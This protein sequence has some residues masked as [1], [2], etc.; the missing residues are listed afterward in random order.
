MAQIK[1]I[2]PAGDLGTYPESSELTIQLEAQNPLAATV[3][4]GFDPR[5]SLVGNGITGDVNVFMP[6]SKDRWSLTTRNLP[7]QVKTGRFPNTLNP[8]SITAQFFNPT[9]P[10]RGGLNRANTTPQPPTGPIGVSSVGIVL[11]G[12]S[13]DR[14]IP[15]MTDRSVWTLNAPAAALFGEDIYGGHP[16]D[17]GIY[18][19]RDST[20][21]TNDAWRDVPGWNGVYTHPDGHSKIIGWAADGYPIYGPMGYREPMSANSGVTNMRSGFTASRT[22]P[23]RPIDTSTTVVGTAIRRDRIRI[24][25]V[26][27]VFLGMC[28]DLIDRSDWTPG[29]VRVIEILPGGEIR[30]NG[31]VSVL[32]K[33]RIR[34]YY[35]LGVFLEDWTYTATVGT[36]LDDH[37]GRFCVTPDFPAGT[38]AYFATQDNTGKPTYPYLIG[39]TFYGSPAPDGYMGEANLDPI[40]QA[41]LTFTILS[42]S[43][44]PGL[45]LQR[46][47]LIYGY[48]T[49]TQAGESIAKRYEFTVR[50]RN[51]AGQVTDRGFYINVNDIR[52]P[53]IASSIESLGFYFD[54]DYVNIQLVGIALARENPL[55]W[56]VAKGTLPPGLEVSQTGL[57]SGFAL[58]PAVAGPAGSAAYDVGRY[59]QFVWDF[60]GSTLSRTYKFTVRIFDSIN[61]AERDYSM[62]VYAR[63]FF[64]TDNTLIT[65]DTTQFTA[66]VDG[67]QYPSILTRATQLP[68]VRQLQSYAFQFN[69]YYANPNTQVLWRINAS[70]P[71][72][73]DQ[74]AVPTPDDNGNY[75]DPVS[76]DQ[77]SF[78]QT[79]LTLPSGLSVDETTGWLSGTL[80]TTTSYEQYYDFDVVAYVRIAVSNTAFSIR[81]SQPVRFRLR[82]LQDVADLITWN[83]PV[84]LGSIDNGDVSTILIS[85]E[86][87]TGQALTYRIKSGQYLRIPQGLSLLSTGEISGRTSFDYFSLDRN[88]SQIFFDNSTQTY[89]SKFTFT[90][91]AQNSDATVY[92]E[93]AFELVVKNVN[94]KPY[95]NLYFKALLPAGLR[96]IFRSLVN[97]PRLLTSEVLY[98]PSDPYFGA[99]NDL[100]LLAVAGLNA[101]TAANYIDSIKNY[102]Y[103]KQV[104]LG[105]IK[106]AV[107]RAGGTGEIIYEVLYVDVIDYNLSSVGG[108]IID[109]NTSRTLQSDD[110][111]SIS[112][113]VIDRE[114]YQSTIDKSTTRDDYGLI[115]DD[116]ITAT[117]MV[118]S[119]SFAN[120][121][122]ELENGIGFQYKGAL[123]LWMLSVQPDT[124]AAPGF[125]R[126]LVLAYANPG[127][128]DK[129]LYRYR[130][131]LQSSGFGVSDIMN[132]FRFV[133]DRYLW[134]RSLTNNYDPTTQSFNVSKETSFDR[135]PSVGVV[136]QGGWLI[137]NVNTNSNI[138]SVAYYPGKGYLAVGDDSVIFNSSGGQNWY[139]Q[140][141]QTDLSYSAAPIFETAVN[142]TS[143]TFFYT[144]VFTVGDEAL[145]QNG[146]NANGH[147][148]IT[149]IDHKIRLDSNIS[150]NLTAGTTLDFINPFDGSITL[151]NVTVNA[152][153]DDIELYIDNLVDIDR[154]FMVMVSGLNVA[155]AVAVD[156]VTDSTVVLTTPTTNLIPAG[157]SITFDNLS[158]YTQILVTANATAA[159]SNTITFNT[160]GNVTTGYYPTLTA[161]PLGVSIRAKFTE[162]ELDQSV[163]PDPAYAGVAI[164]FRGVITSDAVVGEQIISLSNTT[165]IGV[166]SEVFNVVVTADAINSE[167]DQV[168]NDT[169]VIV[170]VS[171]SNIV[172]SIYR[173]MRVVSPLLPDSAK[174]SD[175]AVSLE[176]TFVH[177]VFSNSSFAAASN[178][179]LGFLSDAVTSE[180][181]T[182]VAKTATSITLSDPLI[183]DLPIGADN[184]IQF[185]LADTSLN[186]VIHADDRWVI[187]GAKGLVLDKADGDTGWNQR[188]ALN[189][190]DLFAVAYG[191]GVYIAVGS[192]GIIIRSED[193]ETWSNPV[194]LLGNRSLRS[195]AYHNGVWITVGDGGAILTSTNNGLT[196]AIDTTTTNFRL[197][198]V[199]YI[200]KWVA[201]GERGMVLSKNN[202]NDIW[203]TYN[204]GVTDT[205]NSV[206]YINN[207]YYVSGNRGLIAISSDTNSWTVQ[208]RVVTT[209]L[210]DLPIG[211]PAPVIVGQQGIV[212][213]ESDVFTVDWAIRGIAFDQI[214]WNSADDLA[215]NGYRVKNGELLIFAQQEGLG[216]L[217]D[218]WNLYDAPYAAEELD[219]GTFDS[220][221]IVP[222]F[223]ENQQNTLIS[224]QRAGIWRINV[225]ENNIVTLNFI[226][227]VNLNQV[228]TVKNEVAKLFLDPSIKPGNTVPAYS[229]LSDSTRE[230][231]QDTSFDGEGTRFADNKDSYTEPGSLDKYLKFLKSGV[232]R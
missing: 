123:P 211:A 78:D 77:K 14:R 109:T 164:D 222:G 53:V 24:K 217:N 107:A 27:T 106:K 42:G 173:G 19:Y 115:T 185:G 8:N 187:V 12:P 111:G 25:E 155:S 194:A 87:V 75:F 95:E 120:M 114:D 204:V 230:A 47:G 226:R 63:S 128:G 23:D 22:T 80:G 103:D 212:L 206:S 126:A 192:E 196:W 149:N 134:D 182:V 160:I 35:P 100:R 69:A 190:G 59:D 229:L 180:G 9:Y 221:Q 168:V 205:L 57:I 101:E 58:A 65:V 157:T 198:K 45:Q 203:G 98:R 181:T 156:S 191:N 175:L 16:A 82:V 70:G 215:V 189:Y 162:I 145:R 67:Y 122:K 113:L 76:Y 184:L 92:D 94:T 228:V 159:N 74:G 177:L 136:D 188:Y 108:E 41:E 1:W 219:S 60:E 148:F 40:E 90:V 21:I 50:I 52:P 34:A 161:L 200:N 36:A 97:D 112:E 48:P 153:T 105:T 15:G 102:H 138:N 49:V 210:Y 7:G 68:S 132:T 201:V 207:S 142:G 172:G 72:V 55:Q 88:N 29:S 86:T 2:T 125:T 224:N 37:N 171:N 139:S 83:T 118:Y 91:I 30:L 169:T 147:A 141:Q 130:S 20:F 129:L 213:S 220:L 170:T 183:A 119:N 10:Y 208:S 167:W 127:Q 214:N 225:D 135:I 64:R 193:L 39:P 227:Q 84:D 18:N 51:A 150:A 144:D 197:N 202:Y 143:L 174:V 6:T 5:T 176:N 4:T 79:N 146:F 195:I 46:T 231:T 199:A 3:D 71:S 186:S 163:W 96:N 44:P 28:I 124:G 62:T 93:R 137:R 89:D 116:I 33:D 209:A 151:G 31:V 11:F 66:D 73:F 99:P 140:G 43:L 26:G 158:G 218:G 13:A 85:A 54:S 61:Y 81:E 165:R 38:Y 131:S 223:F 56:T 32:D 152:V 216:Q 179:T 121:S 117:S 17:G 232:F 133:A 166:G 154:G 110:Y 104:N 178:V